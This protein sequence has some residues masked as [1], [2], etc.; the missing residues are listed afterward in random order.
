MELI[1]FNRESAPPDVQ[2]YLDPFEPAVLDGLDF[3]I[4][5]RK[6][7]AFV[8]HILLAIRPI[9]PLMMGDLELHDFQGRDAARA[10]L[11]AE[12][13]AFVLTFAVD[14][15][16]RRQGIGAALQLAAVESCRRRGLRQMRSWSS[17]DKADNYRLKLRLGFAAVPGVQFIPRLGEWVPGAYFVLPLPVPMGSAGRLS[18]SEK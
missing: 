17:H 16:H 12:R 7:G 2:A 8:G 13:E 1:E 6:D 10:I 11:E 14:S 5:A 9:T 3:G 15:A 4:L 18:R